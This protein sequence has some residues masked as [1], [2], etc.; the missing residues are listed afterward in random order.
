MMLSLGAGGVGAALFHLVAHGAAKAMLFLGA[1][2]VMHAMH[3]ETDIRKMGGLSKRMP[4]TGWTFAI[5]AASLAGVIPLAGFFTKDEVLLRVLEYRHPV[6]IV[7]ALAG[8]I[9]SAL[10]MARLTFATFFGAPKADHSEVHE[11]PSVMTVPL[12]LLAVPAIGVGFFA[13]GLG[14]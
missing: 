10:Y 2:S 4:I 5:G 9:L 7:L 13:F 12:L 11:S 8:V 6:F 3:E 1:G 14:D